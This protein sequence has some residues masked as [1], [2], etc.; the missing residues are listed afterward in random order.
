MRVLSYRW[1]SCYP[2]SKTAS[3]VEI[4]ELKAATIFLIDEG[5]SE[6]D[7]M[8]ITT[9]EFGHALGFYGHANV[10]PI[11]VMYASMN[12]G[13]ELSFRDYYQILQIWNCMTH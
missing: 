9:H 7:Q 13:T 12:G 10:S 5:H 1:G 3:V 4:I 11:D 8:C 6:N 2:H